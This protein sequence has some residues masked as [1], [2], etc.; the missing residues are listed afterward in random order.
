[1]PAGPAPPP[2]LARQILQALGD[3]RE[4]GGTVEL[5]L[6][7]PEL[8]RLRLSFVEVGGALTLAIMADRGDTAEMIRRHLPLLAQEFARA[9]LDAPSVDISGGGR[10]D[11]PP[12]DTPGGGTGAPQPDA[13]RSAPPP[14]PAPAAQT[15][16]GG[17][18]LRL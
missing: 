6:D 18:D 2:T 1:M 12:P 11:R 13:P 15:A 16:A 3:A 8:G 5:T 7:P 14:R 9:G 10:G 17:L 4:P